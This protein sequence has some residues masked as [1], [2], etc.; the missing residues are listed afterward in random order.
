MKITSKEQKSFDRVFCLSVIEYIPEA[1]WQ[2][3]IEEFE[4]IL[5]PEGRLIITLD[6]TP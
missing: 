3:C 4:R 6:M 1:F 5:K 2:R